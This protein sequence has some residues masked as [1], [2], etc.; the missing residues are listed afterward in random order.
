ML[1]PREKSENRKNTQKICQQ[2]TLQENYQEI[3]TDG[4][5]SDSTHPRYKYAHYENSHSLPRPTHFPFIMY[6][7]FKR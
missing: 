3:I 5:I 2:A 1:Y 4:K 7:L 6:D